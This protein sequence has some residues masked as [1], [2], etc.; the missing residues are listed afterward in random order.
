MKYLKDTKNISTEFIKSQ[1]FYKN[2]SME[3]ISMEVSTTKIAQ[4]LN[5]H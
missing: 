2:I 3:N 1:H 5:L 4:M